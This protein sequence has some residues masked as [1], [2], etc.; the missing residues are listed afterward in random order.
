MIK[1][2][3]LVFAATLLSL[4]VCEVAVRAFVPVRNV[5]PAFSIYDPEYGKV[6]KADFSTVRKT[7]EFAMTF[8]TNS[9]RMRG[10]EVDLSAEKKI[11]FLGDS[12]TMG[13]GVS[14]GDEFPARIRE[15]LHRMGLPFEVLNAGVGDTGNGRWLKL[16]RNEGASEFEPDLVVFQFY[17]NDL[18]DNL[19]EGLYDISDKGELQ[20]I[21]AG[22]IPWTR[23]VQPLLDLVPCLSH[24]YL[25]GLL[26]QVVWSLSRQSFEDE[27]GGMVVPMANAMLEDASRLQY[28]I[29]ENALRWCRERSISTLGV[30]V[31][32]PRDA[33]KPLYGLFDDVGAKVVEVPGK[34]E[35]PDLYFKVDGHWHSGG[36]EYVAGLLIDE[37]ERI[38]LR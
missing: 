4:A 13:Y 18:M 3:G 1:N 17:G 8:T 26:K 23:K 24:S 7:P 5:G 29:V 20:E 25:L 31:G 32:M 28:L 35:R 2:L 33:Y 34:S 10:E 15:W 16:L 19:V 36:H 14:D 22:S 6:L 37:L 38:F 9:L 12:F 11:L 27:R 30:F 21:P